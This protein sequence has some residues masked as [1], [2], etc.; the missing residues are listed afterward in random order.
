MQSISTIGLDIAKSVFQVDGVDAAGQV[1]MRRQLRH[2]QDV[3]RGPRRLRHSVAVAAP[4][5]HESR[6][7]EIQ[8]APRLRCMEAR[9]VGCGPQTADAGGG[10]SVNVLLRGGDRNRG[11]GKPRLCCA[12]GA[13]RLLKDSGLCDRPSTSEPDPSG[14]CDL[15]QN[16]LRELAHPTKL[17]SRRLAPFVFARSPRIAPFVH[18]SV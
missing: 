17:K 18:R 4:Q 1:V 10:R 8:A 11:Y 3:R 7:H 6:L 15:A 13:G 2:R 16:A 9:D 12:H 5:V 14:R